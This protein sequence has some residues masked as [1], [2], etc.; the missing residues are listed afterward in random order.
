MPGG[1]A[2]DMV[3]YIS[4]GSFKKDGSVVQTPVWVAPLD[5]KL[6]VY[7]LRE[8]YKIKR[9]QRNPKVRVAKCDVRGN[10]LG[11]WFDGTCQVVT[12][13]EHER[14]AYAAFREKYGLMMRLG[15]VMSTL[16]GRIKRRVILEITLSDPAGAA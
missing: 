2:L 8:T 3:S 4:L 5:G 11:P 9:V 14:R 6:V 7:T 1:T 12:D 10:V 13:P 16:T 15:D